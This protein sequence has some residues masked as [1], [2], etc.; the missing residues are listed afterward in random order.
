[1]AAGVYVSLGATQ[2]NGVLCYETPG[3]DGDFA[4]A[5]PAAGNPVDVDACAPL[6]SDG[7]LVGP[8]G[9]GSVCAP[10]LIGCV[11]DDGRL[12]VFPIG[13]RSLCDQLELG[14]FEES[15]PPAPDRVSVDDALV[16]LFESGDCTTMDNAAASIEE[17]LS[18]VEGAEAW[19]VELGVQA[20]D[21][22]NFSSNG[23]L[24]QVV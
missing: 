22:S 11:G 8:C 15:V 20:P 9:D 19:Q 5:V 10:E 18:S 1:M 13:D 2:Q 24:A 17:H 3:I 4:V 16:E 23:V 14:E 7:T 21:Q 6:W 12:L